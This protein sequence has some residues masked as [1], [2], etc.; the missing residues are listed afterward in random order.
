MTVAIEQGLEQVG[1]FL[2][3]A[4]YR[5]VSLTSMNEMVD[6]VVYRQTLPDSALFEMDAWLPERV[7]NRFH[8]IFM[9][10]AGDKTPE[11][12]DIILRSRVYSPLF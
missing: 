4:G 10:N 9:V 2:Q 1:D 12:I 11:Q 5:V 6:A 8:G 7:R 3:C